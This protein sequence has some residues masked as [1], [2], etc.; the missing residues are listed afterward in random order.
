MAQYILAGLWRHATN[1][2]LVCQNIKLCSK[3]YVKRDLKR[4]I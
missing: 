4:D 3:E 1:P 2:H